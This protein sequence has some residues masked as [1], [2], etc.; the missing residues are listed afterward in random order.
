MTYSESWAFLQR[1][2]PWSVQLWPDG[3]GELADISCG[4]PWYEQ[5]DGKNPGS[6]LILARTQKG[7]EIIKGAIEAGYLTAKSA[8]LWK[9]EKSQPGLLK[10]KGAVWGR[11]LAMRLFGLPVTKLENAHL[12]HSWNQLSF[13]EKVRS[14]IGTVRRIISRKLY[15]PLKLDL[16]DSVPVK[17]A[18][19]PS[20]LQKT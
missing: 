2:R 9:I 5:P 16:K 17:P 20:E 4:D 6:S 14:T 10:K 8:E 18:C 13:A 12:F 11:R 19:I 1:F 15:K 3:S 7:L